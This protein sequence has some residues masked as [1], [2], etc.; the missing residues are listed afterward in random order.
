ME[1]NEVRQDIQ[2]GWLITSFFFFI[3]G[4][5]TWFVWNE[6]RPKTARLCAVAG[7]LGFIALLTIMYMN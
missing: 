5:I 6:S 3:I 4:F 1:K 2:F 7:T